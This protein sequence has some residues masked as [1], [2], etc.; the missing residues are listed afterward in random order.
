MLFHVMLISQGKAALELEMATPL[1][2]S[3]GNPTDRSLAGCKSMGL[4]QVGYD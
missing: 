2:Y 4:Q 3:L 1:Q